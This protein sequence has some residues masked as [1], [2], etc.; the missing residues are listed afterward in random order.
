MKKF[1]VLILLLTVFVA[2]TVLVSCGE[3]ATDES[4]FEF[5]Q[6][7][8]NTYA[9]SCGEIKLL[10]SIVIPKKYNG[11]KVT[12]IMENGFKDCTKLKTIVIPDSVT[13]IGSSAFNGCS[14]LTSIAIP[15]KVTSIGDSAFRGCNGLTSIVIP[16]SVISIGASAFEGCSSLSS[17]TL[18]FVG[19]GSNQTHF[20]YIFGDSSYDKD[21]IPA[22][23][24]SVTIT[25]K[26]SIAS[27]AFLGCS[28]LNS[29]VISNSVTSIGEGAFMGCSSLENISLPFIGNGSDKAHFGYIFGAF[30][31]S[32]NSICVP[33]SLKS[34]T[35]TGGTSV[36]RYAFYECSNLTSIVVPSSVTS[37]GDSAFYGCSR[38]TSIAIPNKVT[39]IGDSAFRGCSGFTSVVI[40]DS[41]TSVGGN[42]FYGCNGLTSIVIPN[43]V[44]SIGGYAFYGCDKLTIHCKAQS[45]PSSWNSDWNYSN[46]T[47]E[48][49]YKG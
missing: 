4:Y 5:Y 45:K 35:I 15:N 19:D 47:V 8:D 7:E 43:S 11:K 38:L 9:I 25:G 46:R 14:R 36:G 17:I 33:T 41:V 28:S 26:T 37:I 21:C 34:V 18:P 30:D 23:L 44:T 16:N 3:K 27:Y 13:S 24:K 10:S 6:L 22:T 32:I 12:A 31:Y 49:G 48:W 20:E 39:S 40:P 42:A 1:S 2:L 29:I